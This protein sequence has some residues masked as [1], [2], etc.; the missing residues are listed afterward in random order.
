MKEEME[1][2]ISLQQIDSEISGFNQAIAKCE[3]NIAKREQSIQEKQEKLSA[4]RSK[5]ERLTEKQ[6]ENQNEHDEATA[7]V[8]DRQ[9]KMLLVQT[10]REH[11]AL[12][13]EI[14]E[15]KKIAKDTEERALQFI[16]QLEQLEGVA[17]ALENLAK[18][19]QEL[20]SE[21]QQNS[22]KEI[23]R[24]NASKKNIEGERA[25][26]AAAVQTAHMQRYTKLIAKRAGLAVVAVQDSVCLGCHM[27]LPPQQVNEVMKGDKL[28]VCPTCQRILYYREAAESQEET[29]L[30]E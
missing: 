25:T 29:T 11:Q 1:K 20:L 4:L 19:E 28:N 6:E 3:D 15:N 16:E 17:A 27:T 8:K 23:K 14:E 30:A 24:L 26:K 5:I 21:E 22:A 12:L 9:N 18:G 7:R 13:K 2:L 10:S